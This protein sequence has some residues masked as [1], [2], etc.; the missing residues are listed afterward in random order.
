MMFFAYPATSNGWGGHGQHK[1]DVSVRLG[2]I[3]NDVDDFQ[4]RTEGLARQDIIGR[5][6]KGV[7][8]ARGLPKA[9]LLEMM[10]G[11]QLESR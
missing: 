10:G 11:R 4:I 9:S 7:A 6:N 3:A 1:G 2:V 8:R 5:G